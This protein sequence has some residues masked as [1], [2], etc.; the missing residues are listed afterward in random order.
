[1]AVSCPPVPSCP[2][3]AELVARRCAG[4]PALRWSPGADGMRSRGSCAWRGRATTGTSWLRT[5][6]GPA[7]WSPRDT[8]VP[9]RPVR[10]VTAASPGQ[11]AAGAAAAVRDGGGAH[12]VRRFAA[13]R[14]RAG[15]GCGGRRSVRQRARARPARRPQ[16]GRTTGQPICSGEGIGTRHP[17]HFRPVTRWRRALGLPGRGLGGT[18][19]AGLPAA[20]PA[21]RFRWPVRV[22]FRRRSILPGATA[23]RSTAGRSTTDVPAVVVPATAPGRAVWLAVAVRLGAA[24]RRA[25]AVRLV[26]CGG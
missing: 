9:S 4:R 21:G 25:S 3:G 17:H 13:G 16:P 5:E 15:R 10:L 22:G 1:M 8:G 12:D 19:R 11:P 23:G 20:L 18:R 7:S 14:P 2:P 6:S 24:V 26:W